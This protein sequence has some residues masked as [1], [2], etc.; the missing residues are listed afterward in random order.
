MDA[1]HLEQLRE[2]LIVG[3]L[4]H[5]FEVIQGHDRGRLT[6]V[7]SIVIDSCEPE[8]C[9]DA[10]RAWVL[11]G[12]HVLRAFRVPH[13]SLQSTNHYH[14]LRMSDPTLRTSLEPPTVRLSNLP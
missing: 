10:I 7:A 4:E 1:A 8:E 5:R 13:A 2:L 9:T 11:I 12:C 6:C 14:S 3:E